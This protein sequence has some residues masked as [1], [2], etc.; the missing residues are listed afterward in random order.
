MVMAAGGT[1]MLYPGACTRVQHDVPLLLM[2]DPADSAVRMAQ[3]GMLLGSWLLVAGC[4][5]AAGWR[6]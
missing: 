3:R 6:R 1:V 5:Q 4:C 2:T